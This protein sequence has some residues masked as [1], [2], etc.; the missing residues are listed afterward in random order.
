MSAPTDVGFF[1]AVLRDYPDDDPMVV[2]VVEPRKGQLEVFTIGS[3]APWD[4][5][6]FYWGDR[7]EPPGHPIAKV[8]DER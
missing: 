2:E 7:V 1:W 4:M 5:D 3:E 8:G 6:E